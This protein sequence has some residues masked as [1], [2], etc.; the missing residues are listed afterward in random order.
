MAF[1]I[2][3]A[4]SYPDC[5]N[6]FICFCSLPIPSSP[7]PRGTPLS[8]GFSSFHELLEFILSRGEVPTPPPC[9][10][11]TPTLQP[12]ELVEAYGRS[13]G[14][15]PRLLDSSTSLMLSQLGKRGEDQFFESQA[16]KKL[17][18]PTLKRRPLHSQSVGG[19]GELE[20]YLAVS[21]RL[22]SPPALQVHTHSLC[23]I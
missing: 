3:L 7:F 4:M 16:G 22:N 1:I 12:P 5:Y 15:T 6:G 18:S 21:L 13:Y 2:K 20:E 10:S 8:E 19:E 11:L 14:D 17:S 9:V 23:T